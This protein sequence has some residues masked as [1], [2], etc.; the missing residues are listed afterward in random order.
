MYPMNNRL[1]ANVDTIQTFA[2]SGDYVTAP[3]K[4]KYNLNPMVVLCNQ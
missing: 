3:D 2:N 4:Y 1:H